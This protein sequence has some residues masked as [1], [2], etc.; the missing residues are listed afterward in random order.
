MNRH[1]APEFIVVLEGSSEV[2]T[3]GM[4][5]EPGGVVV[6]L[7]LERGNTGHHLETSALSAQRA[8][9][10]W[11]HGIRG[12]SMGYVRQAK[13]SGARVASQPFATRCEKKSLDLRAVSVWIGPAGGQGCCRI[14]ID[15][16]LTDNARDGDGG[17][18]SD[19]AGGV[20][21]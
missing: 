18:C 5:E 21:W 3:L 17:W 14:N 11:G 1:L 15:E 16:R 8:A 20:W 7:S 10:G 12:K 13:S 19:D 4:T 9:G 2:Q 6:F